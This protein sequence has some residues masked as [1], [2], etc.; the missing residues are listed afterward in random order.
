M[1]TN[2]NVT[3]CQLCFEDFD[4]EVTWQQVNHRLPVSCNTCPNSVCY[5]CYLSLQRMQKRNIEQFGGIRCPRCSAERGFSG[6]NPVFNRALVALLAELKTIIGSTI[7][8]GQQAPKSQTLKRTTSPRRA[9]SP[10][11]GLLPKSNSMWVEIPTELRS[12]KMEGLAVAT[13][14]SAK[15]LEVLKVP[16][17]NRSE[18]SQSTRSRR[19][20]IQIKK[21][22]LPI[23]YIQ[24]NACGF[25]S[26]E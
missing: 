15:Q 26:T 13:S 11:A 8:Q 17:D 5:Q 20:E 16:D 24:M 25:G 14:P 2:I 12:P 4:T 1:A 3:V 6:Q 10:T 23:R 9:A 22:A 18:A 7:Q 19:T 21:K